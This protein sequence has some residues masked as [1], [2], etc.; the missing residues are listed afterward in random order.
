MPILAA[1]SAEVL[2]AYRLA[3]RMTTQERMTKNFSIRFLLSLAWL[4]QAQAGGEPFAGI[5]VDV[6]AGFD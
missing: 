2:R 3:L 4:R 5:V 6:G 1:G